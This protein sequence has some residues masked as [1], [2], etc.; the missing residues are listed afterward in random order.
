MAG[1]G[2]MTVSRVTEERERVC[3]VKKL[4]SVVRE[5]VVPESLGRGI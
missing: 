3:G 4:L 2:G 1:G 5:S